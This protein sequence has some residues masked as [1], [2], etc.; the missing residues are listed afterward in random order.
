VLKVN[1]GLTYPE[2]YK[3]KMRAIEISASIFECFLD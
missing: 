2:G 1:I 3:S